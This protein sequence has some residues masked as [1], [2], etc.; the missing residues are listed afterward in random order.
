[1]IQCRGLEAAHR[2]VRQQAGD[3]LVL[4]LQLAAQLLDLELQHE[5][6]FLQ[7]LR[8]ASTSFKAG[9]DR[10]Q[11]AGYRS[12]ETE[13]VFR[14]Q[15]ARPEQLRLAVKRRLLDHVDNQNGHT[16]TGGNVMRE[17]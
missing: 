11:D 8:W 15:H 17:Q 16:A 4:G 3:A 5:L 7:L 12:Q 13:Q 1:M 10:M 2:E 14:S 9:Q 6:Q